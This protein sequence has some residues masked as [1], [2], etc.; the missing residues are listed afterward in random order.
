MTIEI[1]KPELEKLIEQRMKSG[2]YQSIED[3]LLHALAPGSAVPAEDEVT[4]AALVA[5]LQACPLKDIDLEPERFP[6][7]VCDVVF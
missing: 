7:P 1:R 2:A 5:A 4:G 3:V 6:M